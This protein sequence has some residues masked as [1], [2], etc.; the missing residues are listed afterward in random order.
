M[1]LGHQTTNLGVRSSNL[2][3]R[4]NEFNN[5]SVSWPERKNLRNV[6]AIAME[7]RS[8]ECARS[9]SSD[10]APMTSGNGATAPGSSLAAGRRDHA[11]FNTG[12][13]CKRSQRVRL[14]SRPCA[15]HLLNA[16]LSRRVTRPPGLP[17][18][19]GGLA[20]DGCTEASAVRIVAVSRWRRLCTGGSTD[21]L[22]GPARIHRGP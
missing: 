15:E 19:G 8:Q 14:A 6:S 2:F 3:G 4:A 16:K 21:A 13:R 20:R 22:K 12:E 7:V 18:Q 11:E 10:A 9:K 1:P 17:A 5:L